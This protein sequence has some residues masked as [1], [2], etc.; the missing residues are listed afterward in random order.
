MTTATPERMKF[1]PTEKDVAELIEGL[2]N[3]LK[4]QAS[5]APAL[6]L[7]E[8][9]FA[10]LEQAILNGQRFQ[11]EK[12]DSSPKAIHRM[13]QDAENYANGQGAQERHRTPSLVNLWVKEQLL[14]KGSFVSRYITASDDV[15]SRTRNRSLDEHAL[16]QAQLTPAEVAEM[17]RMFQLLDR[18]VDP[19][20][21]MA[22]AKKRENAKYNLSDPVQMQL[23]RAQMRRVSKGLE[24]E[25]DRAPQTHDD[26][27]TQTVAVDLTKLGKYAERKFEEVVLNLEK[28]TMRLD[29]TDPSFIVDPRQWGRQLEKI[30]FPSKQI[31]SK[32]LSRFTRIV[33]NA[34][35]LGLS[36]LSQRSQ[37]D[38]QVNAFYR[39]GERKIGEA[40]VPLGV[41]A[42]KFFGNKVERAAEMMLV[43]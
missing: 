28:D 32:G 12:L 16:A 41:R 14:D 11:Q 43:R 29:K 19:S 5:S 27:H 21:E 7:S 23:N 25:I 1:V 24:T 15:R 31:N 34:L 6:T 17:L 20:K 30:G 9:Q 26:E 4:E 40:Y 36:R 18:L 13:L 35:R 37:F 22:E 2:E 10:E 3:L 8:E 33:D 42:G 38:P 39:P